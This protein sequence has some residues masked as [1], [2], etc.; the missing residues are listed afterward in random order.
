MQGLKPW[1]GLSEQEA[2]TRLAR[3]GPNLVHEPKSRSLREIL[4]ETLP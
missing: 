2:S 1:Q 3:F 4:N